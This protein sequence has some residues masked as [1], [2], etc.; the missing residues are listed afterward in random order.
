MHGLT[1]RSISI[2][3]GG[4]SNVTSEVSEKQKFVLTLRQA[5]AF[6]VCLA[7]RHIREPYAGGGE[8]QSSV[9]SAGAV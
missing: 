3:K 8:A 4:N 1:T 5:R 9:N 6:A 2:R 7:N